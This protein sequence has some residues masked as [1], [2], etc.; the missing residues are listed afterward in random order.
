[1]SGKNCAPAPKGAPKGKGMKPVAALPPK[2]PKG[3]KK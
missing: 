2:A 3:G 1:M